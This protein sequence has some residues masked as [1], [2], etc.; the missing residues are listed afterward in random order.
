MQIYIDG[1][2]GYGLT[3]CGTFQGKVPT[4]SSGPGSVS[5][6]CFNMIAK[7][8][9]FGY[10]P[11]RCMDNISHCSD[12]FTFGMWVQPQSY[13]SS[14][15]RY[16][17][18]STG[19]WMAQG[20]GH[21]L[22]CKVYQDTRNG[23]KEWTLYK[24]NVFGLNEWVHVVVSWDKTS[25]FKLYLNGTLVSI[26]TSSRATSP[27]KQQDFLMGNDKIT[28]T[29]GFIGCLGNFYFSNKGHNITFIQ[30]IGQF[31]SSN[32][33]ITTEGDTPGTTTVS[34]CVINEN[35]FINTMIAGNYKPYLY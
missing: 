32:V 25:G 13:Y 28:Q 15:Y 2:S 14:Q 34:T 21:Q 16:L 11:S 30:A 6:L 33:A 22:V 8:V 26:V 17:M 5:A 23:V 18:G 12:G 19:M 35:T 4:E 31:A 20:L 10:D 9:N 1:V 27:R 7:A 3:N 24:A 29:N